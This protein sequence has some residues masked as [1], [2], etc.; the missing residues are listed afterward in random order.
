MP[1]R[2]RQGV[3]L[4]IVAIWNPLL[5]SGEGRGR[6]A[7]FLHAVRESGRHICLYAHLAAGDAH[8]DAYR[9]WDVRANE[10]RRLRVERNLALKVPFPAT[11]LYL[12]CHC[13]FS[14]PSREQQDL[15]L[16]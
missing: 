1:G 10:S 5:K 15:P 8:A 7:G 14:W 6:R 16:T 9:D 2:Q 3:E 12:P 4:G 11:L 13:S